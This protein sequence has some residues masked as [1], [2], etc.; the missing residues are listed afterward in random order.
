LLVELG[1]SQQIPRAAIQCGTSTE[2]DGGL[3]KTNNFESSRIISTF[4]CFT[5]TVCELHCYWWCL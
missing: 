5:F 4:A 3:G 1:F 2:G